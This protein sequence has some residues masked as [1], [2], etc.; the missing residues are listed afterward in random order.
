MIG[1]KHVLARLMIA[2]LLGAA[3]IQ[4]V[5][6][7]CRSDAVGHHAIESVNHAE[8]DSADC[9]VSDHACDH[10]H[11]DEPHP[12]DC[13]DTA[14]VDD[15]VPLRDGDLGVQPVA[16]MSVVPSMVVLPSTAGVAAVHLCSRAPPDLPRSVDD[17][18]ILRL[19]I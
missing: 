16:V 8:S 11:D 9:V 1:Y 18:L 12:E 6:V 4:V 3:C 10:S 14:V 7:E 19:V 13:T 2:V 15:V 5:V 17:F